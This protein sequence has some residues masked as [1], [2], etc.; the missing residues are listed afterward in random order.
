LKQSRKRQKG[1][2]LVEFVLVMSLVMVPLMLGTMVV[3]FNLIRAIQVNQVNRDAGHMFAR[4][5]DFSSDPNGLLDRSILFQMAPRLQV[6]T[7][8]GTGVLI[9]SAIE[10]IGPNTCSSCS[11]LSHA[12]FTQQITIGNSAL[13]ASDMGTVLA[14]SMLAD[15][16]GTV[17]NPTTDTTVRADP[18]LNILSMVDGQVAYVSETFY[19]STDLSIPGY[20]TASGVYA[21]AIF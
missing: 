3:G 21:R 16:S 10:Y 9:L 4:G 11:N 18:I 7:S 19:G 15:G 2:L 5:V 17:T 13:R 12:V 8:A 1:S 20:L 14:T 6:T